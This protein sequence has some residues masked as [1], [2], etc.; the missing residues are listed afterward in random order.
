MRRTKASDSSAGPGS[1][2]L[3]SRSSENE[4]ARIRLG[5]SLTSCRGTRSIFN[6]ILALHGRF[7]SETG[8][9]LTS[10]RPLNEVHLGPEARRD[11]IRPIHLAKNLESRHPRAVSGSRTPHPQLFVHARGQLADLR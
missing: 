10:P 5:G 8:K 7:R 2:W 6:I 1:M 4:P 9:S 3:N 11:I